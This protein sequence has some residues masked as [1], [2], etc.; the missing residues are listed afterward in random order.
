MLENVFCQL[1]VLVPDILS[2][3]WACGITRMNGLLLT[4][5]GLCG[6]DD[7][8]SIQVVADG[9]KRCK[10]SVSMTDRTPADRLAPQTTPGGL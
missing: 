6:D 9:L 2:F 3:I 8:G 5:V 10:V 1:S 7:G 4:L